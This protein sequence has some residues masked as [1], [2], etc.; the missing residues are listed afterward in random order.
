MRRFWLVVL[1]VA[2]LPLRG[3][4]AAGMAASAPPSGLHAQAEAHAV[5]CHA[6]ASDSG[7]ADDPG[8]PA[9]DAHAV[10]A[11]HLCFSCDLCHAALA[12][13]AAS[14]SSPGQVPGEGPLVG[15][16]RDT[17]RLLAG[18]LERPPRA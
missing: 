17:G 9:H 14:S 2:L 6:D 4:A 15:P 10:Q 8:A 3:W 1:L 13:V 12:P 18:C 16:S 5:P 7:S 11:S